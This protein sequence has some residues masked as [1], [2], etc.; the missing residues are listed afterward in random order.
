MV[1]D[2][3]LTALDKGKVDRGKIMTR[4]LRNELS[5]LYTRSESAAKFHDEKAIVIDVLEVYENWRSDVLRELD[6]DPSDPE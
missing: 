2:Y 3:I 6:P 4:A 5:D 1:L